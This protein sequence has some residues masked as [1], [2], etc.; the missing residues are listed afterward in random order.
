MQPISVR[1]GRFLS[2]CKQDRSE[3]SRLKIS[4]VDDEDAIRQAVSFCDGLNV[5]L[6]GRRIRGLVKRLPFN[7]ESGCHMTAADRPKRCMLSIRKLG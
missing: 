6:W 1:T 7:D 3:A 5:E 4:A 2:G